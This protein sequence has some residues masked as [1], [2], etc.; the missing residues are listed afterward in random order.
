MDRDKLVAALMGTWPVRAAKSGLAAI[1][2]PGDVYQ[3]NVSMWGE[4]GRTNPEVIEKSAD[5][6]G[7]VM[8]GSYAAPAMKDATGMGIRA[9]HGSPH[10]FDK[11]DLSKIGTGEGAQAYGRGLYFAEHEGVAKGYRDKLSDAGQ[12]K[13][14][15]VNIKADPAHMMDW[16]GKLGGQPQAVQDVFAKQL[17]QFGPDARM[18]AQMKIASSRLP[19]G[20]AELSKNLADAGVPGI[21]YLDQGSRGAGEGSRNFVVFDDKLIDI[22]KKY[23][24]SSVA[25]LP[26]LVQATLGMS[27]DQKL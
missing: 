8:G 2:L 18:S 6:G 13:M 17:A 10:D 16:D 11:F 4:D 24:V 22:L 15:E 14:Y 20:Q 25:A 12:G 7:L 21:Q 9:Y 27:G 26:P 23:G 3:G 19:G 5:L 1:Q